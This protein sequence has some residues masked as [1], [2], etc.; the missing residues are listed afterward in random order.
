MSTNFGTGIS[1]KALVQKHIKMLRCPFFWTAGHLRMVGCRFVLVPP[2]S[3][4]VPNDNVL[5]PDIE[6][7][8][9]DL[10][11][12]LSR[13]DDL[14]EKLSSVRDLFVSPTLPYEHAR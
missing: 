11:H 14:R 6:P 13:V 3:Y 9:M 2:A 1:L 4:P 7:H 5:L 8:I 12:R 10:V